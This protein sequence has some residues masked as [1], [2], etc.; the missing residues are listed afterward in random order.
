MDQ[1][2]GMN[3]ATH[4]Y[5]ERTLST[6]EAHEAHTLTTLTTLTTLSN[7]HSKHTKHLLVR[8]GSLRQRDPDWSRAQRVGR[9]ELDG[10]RWRQGL[11]GAAGAQA[12]S[13]LHGHGPW[14]GVLLRGSVVAW[15]QRG[16]QVSRL[17][18]R[19]YPC[20]SLIHI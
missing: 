17:L 11:V 1:A 12:V 16:R 4:T 7:K 9:V 19:K 10:L 18:R 14:L 13:Q 6:H 15:Q 3:D 20:L 5:T 2:K 8:R